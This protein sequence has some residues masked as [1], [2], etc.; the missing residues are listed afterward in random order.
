MVL[1][2]HRCEEP[3]EA[4]LFLRVYVI[5]KF[6]IPFFFLQNVC[7]MA[8]NGVSHYIQCIYK[9]NLICILMCFWSN[10]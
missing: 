5:T 3:I 2:W 10:M 4:P 8:I 7:K 6:D 1:L 9:L